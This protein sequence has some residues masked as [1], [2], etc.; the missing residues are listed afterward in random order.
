MFVCV[1]FSIE[2]TQLSLC[3]EFLFPLKGSFQ[4]NFTVLSW[5]NLF[6]AMEM[7]GERFGMSL[8]IPNNQNYLLNPLPRLSFRPTFFLVLTLAAARE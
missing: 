7:Q 4:T 3:V 5:L 8:L 6:F 1:G 2:F